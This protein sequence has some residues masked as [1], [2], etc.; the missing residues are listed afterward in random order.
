M[1]TLFILM[2]VCACLF[3][4]MCWNMSRP[5]TIMESFVQTDTIVNGA[6]PLLTA[7]YRCWKAVRG[8]FRPPEN[9]EP[10]VLEMRSLDA[11][12]GIPSE[13]RAS[14]M[15]SGQSGTTLSANELQRTR[16]FEKVFGTDAPH[17]VYHFPALASDRPGA[18]VFHT[19]PFAGKFWSRCFLVGFV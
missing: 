6:N 18:M 17:L 10:L 11:G 9:P 2:C 12:T 5:P 1:Y 13:T 3:L 16:T 7:P 8:R 4:R 19:C 15:Q 14:S